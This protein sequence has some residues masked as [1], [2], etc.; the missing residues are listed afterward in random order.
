MYLQQFYIVTT[1]DYNFP[2]FL[3]LTSLQNNVKNDL[4]YQIPV[5]LI[6]VQKKIL[7]CIENSF[8]LRSLHYIINPKA[9]WYASVFKKTCV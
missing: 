7:L 1:A 9:K 5:P 6:S 2:F 4:E 3:I 8:Y